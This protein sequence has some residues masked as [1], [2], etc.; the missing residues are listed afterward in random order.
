MADRIEI[1]WG[2]DGYQHASADVTED[3]REYTLQYG[4]DT[5]TDPLI[6]R[7]VSARGI[8]SLFDKA[9][10]YSSHIQAPLTLEQTRTRHLCRISSVYSNREQVLW[11]GLADPIQVVS[12]STDDTVQTTLLGKLTNVYT[13]RFDVN[14]SGLPVSW[15][16]ESQAP[17]IGPAHIDTRDLI[18]GSVVWPSP[19]RT[20]RYRN[21][22][23]GF[24]DALAD[25]ASAYHWE[26]YAGNYA[27]VDFV[28]MGEYQSVI[29]VSVPEYRMLAD[30]TQIYNQIELARNTILFGGD[31]WEW[32]FEIAESV[33][34]YDKLEQQ[35]PKWWPTRGDVFPSMSALKLRSEPIRHVALSFP[36]LQQRSEKHQKNVELLQ[37]G[38]AFD[39]DIMTDDAE[40]NSK[41]M[42]LGCRLINQF[43]APPIMIVYA[44]DTVQLETSE[45]M[46]LGRGRL[47]ES[48]LGDPP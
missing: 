25:F 30:V 5:E 18:T 15:H 27:F 10:K 24:L 7:N 19:D 36:R 12:S 1:D 17:E 16:I 22:R 38:T 3:F 2:D 26:D 13:D 35:A 29:S 42:V 14:Q 6:F 34:M 46:I 32:L 28:R 23:I 39:L 37:P 11:E 47:G 4:M 33:E 44:L 20:L 9:G 41:F 40:V 31:D 45:N 43:D 21:T 8:L 48:V